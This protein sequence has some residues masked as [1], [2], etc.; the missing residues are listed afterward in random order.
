MQYH[1]DAWGKPI[2]TVLTDEGSPEQ[3]E[4]AALNPLLYRGYYYDFE[5]GYYY[6]QSRYYDPNLCRFINSDVLEMSGITKDTE[7]GTN[8]FAYCNNDPVNNSDPTG[9]LTVKISRKII[10][11][12]I[13]MLLALIPGVGGAF[14]PI[15]TI[16]K[17]YGK[18]TLKVKIKTPLATFIRFIIKKA[19]KVINGLKKII[20][21]IPG[22]GKKIANKLVVKKLQQ[23]LASGIA[24][25][26]IN[27]AVNLLVKN[28][29]LI[30]SLGGAISGILDYFVDTS[31]KLDGYL[32]IKI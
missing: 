15:K 2:S 13:D 27:K 18:A 22:L 14:A 29:D 31:R 19:P 26:V 32:R 6:L 1:Y 17:A 21:K 20:T 5:T 28:I 3:Q 7:V 4:I 11:S 25:A 8:M 30:L 12:L 9:M 23:Q 10:A 24:S 16:A